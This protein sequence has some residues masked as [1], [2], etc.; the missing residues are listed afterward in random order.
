MNTNKTKVTDDAFE[1]WYAD[2][3]GTEGLKKALNHPFVKDGDYV[4]DSTRDRVLI[5]QAA[6]QHYER[7]IAE[8]QAHINVLLEDLEEVEHWNDNTQ[9]EDCKNAIEKLCNEAISSTPAQSLAEFENEVIERCA[10]RLDEVM[11][12]D[13][14]SK[15]VRELKGEV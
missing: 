13:M 10:K 15:A 8:L 7:E 3:H 9:G 2:N 4:Y 1:K 11:K 12:T 6:S 14:A 5:W